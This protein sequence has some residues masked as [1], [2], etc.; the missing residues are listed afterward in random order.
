MSLPV[1]PLLKQYG[2]IVEML[3]Q[4]PENKDRIYILSKI[5]EI[6]LNV[7]KF[8][9]GPTYFVNTSGVISFP[10]YLN[11][12]SSKKRKHTTSL[13]YLIM[14][15]ISKLAS[16]IKRWCQSVLQLSLQSKTT[17]KAKFGEA[18]YCLYYHYQN[19]NMTQKWD[20]W[21]AVLSWNMHLWKWKYSLMRRKGN[22][23][24][25]KSKGSCIEVH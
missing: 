20:I 9:Q 24:C 5:C 16:H 3:S 6:K 12:F 17:K 7:L 14:A 23:K 22:R 13:S 4:I 11:P 15:N 2:A 18:K 10:P 25:L 19:R 1:F 21:H 8:F